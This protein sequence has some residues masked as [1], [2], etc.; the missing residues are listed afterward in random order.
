VW[1]LQ[2]DHDNVCG[3]ILPKADKIE[4]RYERNGSEICVSS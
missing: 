4:A 1:F 2:A 3:R